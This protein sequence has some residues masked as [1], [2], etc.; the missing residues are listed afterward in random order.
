MHGESFL[1]LYVPIRGCP[2]GSCV[3]RASPPPTSNRI[4]SSGWRL[5][6]GRRGSGIRR[7]Y[8]RRRGSPAIAG[9]TGTA[10]RSG[11]ANRAAVTFFS[12]GLF[13]ETLRRNRRLPFALPA[14]EDRIVLLG[15]KHDLP[16][17]Q[18]PL[19]SCVARIAPVRR[20]EATLVGN[21]GRS[22]VEMSF[23]LEKDR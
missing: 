23:Y 10:G 2:V 15:N 5:P 4:A 20:L 9:A 22:A 18:A 13:A 7:R 12:C 1:L 19:L 21:C 6:W 14:Y 11:E 3:R 8:S 16:S 17:Q